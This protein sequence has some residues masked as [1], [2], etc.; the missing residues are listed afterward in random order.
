M[1]GGRKRTV[2]AA[3]STVLTPHPNPGRAHLPSYRLLRQSPFRFASCQAKPLGG[4]TS[5]DHTYKCGV[6]FE[7]P[8]SL[9]RHGSFHRACRRRGKAPAQVARHPLPF[10]EGR[11]KRYPRTTWHSPVLPPAIAYRLSADS[12]GCRPWKATARNPQR[13]RPLAR[14]WPIKHWPASLGPLGAGFQPAVLVRESNPRQPDLRS[15][16]LPLS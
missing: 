10:A 2:M 12:A 9:R 16:A 15:G 7:H 14:R 8:H 13:R 11:W 5:G 4:G 3:V 1:N 6:S